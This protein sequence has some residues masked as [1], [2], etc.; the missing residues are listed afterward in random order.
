[1]SNLYWMSKRLR[2]QIFARYPNLEKDPLYARFLFLLLYGS[3]FDNETGGLV[4]STN[5]MGNALGVEHKTRYRNFRVGDFLARFKRDVLPKFEV[6]HWEYIEGRARAVIHDGLDPEVHEWVSNDA[7]HPVVESEL[8]DFVSGRRRTGALRKQLEDEF[9]QEV[10]RDGRCEEPTLRIIRYHNALPRRGFSSVVSKHRPAA[11]SYVN[12]MRAGRS[13]VMT[14]KALHRIMIDPKPLLRPVENS[15]RAFSHQASLTTVKREVRKILTRDWV[16][17]DLRYA[18]LAIV[19]RL[20][21]IPEL[22]EFLEGNTSPWTHLTRTLAPSASDKEQAKDII[23][24]ALYALIFGSSE[25]RAMEIIGKLDNPPSKQEFFSIDLI[26]WLFQARERQLQKITDEGFAVTFYG[27][28]ILAPKN[29]GGR[30]WW[31][32][33]PENARSILAQQAHAIEMELITQIY[34]VLEDRPDDATIMLNQFDGVSVRYDKRLKGSWRNLHDQVID[35]VN[36][37]G[38]EL[39]IPTSLEAAVPSSYPQ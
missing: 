8:V 21:R 9:R 34:D 3:F 22:L 15:V 12:G 19:A 36:V 20:W 13:K 5:I 38:E 10:E 33:Q 29:E 32:D 28:E 6:S 4:V 17:Y 16:E 23:K 35:A 30:R 39:Q 18:Q 26:D 25:K 7:R 24:N 14:E 27:K 31:T 37:R 1:M 2:S 11:W